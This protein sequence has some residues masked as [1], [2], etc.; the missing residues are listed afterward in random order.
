MTSNEHSTNFVLG[1]GI[2]SKYKNDEFS[3]SVI[4][5]SAIAVSGLNQISAQ[6]IEELKLLGWGAGRNN[7]GGSWAEYY[8]LEYVDT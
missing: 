5:T 6:D 7:E 4:E 2:L 8:K 1:I 3:I